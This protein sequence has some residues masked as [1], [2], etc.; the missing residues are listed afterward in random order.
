M[1]GLKI[2]QYTFVATAV[3]ATAL[4]VCVP[5]R[6][7]PSLYA[8]V[9][10]VFVLIPQAAAIAYQLYDIR[11]RYLAYNSA[12]EDWRLSRLSRT[13]RHYRR[14]AMI[15]VTLCTI[16]SQKSTGINPNRAGPTAVPA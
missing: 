5:F 4:V 6:A 16:A 1:N 2:L 13:D 11:Q 3:T 15:I 7:V 9:F 14:T 8:A 12:V 10:V